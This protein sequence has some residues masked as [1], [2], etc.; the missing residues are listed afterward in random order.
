MQRILLHYY[1]FR[2]L[3]SVHRKFPTVS[4]GRGVEIIN[5]KNL[6]L[7][8]NVSFQDRVMLHCGGLDW[9]NFTGGIEIGDNSTISPNCIF[10]GCGSKIVIGKNF[11]CGPAV[12]I[13]SSRTKYEELTLYP[14]K[15]KHVF[16]DVVIGDNVICYTNVVIGPG[17]TI[18]DGAVIG[19]NSTV[20]S[21]V[22]PNT[23]VAGSP[24]KKITTRI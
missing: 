8:K 23:L 18:G 20:L 21:N 22:E 6:V 10:W 15:N 1:S 16:A 12:K 14:D 3:R 11:D 13:F 24:A 2:N 19:A 9:C 5:T 4:F 7:G 17:V